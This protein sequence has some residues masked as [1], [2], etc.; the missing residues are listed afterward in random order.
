MSF[1][2]QFSRWIDDSL[3]ADT[4]SSVKAFSFNLCE[5]A[6]IAGVKF[7]VELIGAG[8]FD[9]DDPDWA[10]NDVWEPQVRGIPIPKNY[11][12]ES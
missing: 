5:P 4:P 2:D 6:G 1:E 11:S 7:G 8:T 3:A 9:E 10:C 12:G